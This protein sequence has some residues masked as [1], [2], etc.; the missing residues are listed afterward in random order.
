MLQQAVLG[1]LAASVHLG[2]GRVP[3]ALSAII[4]RLWG[5]RA[6]VESKADL[7]EAAQEAVSAAGAGAAAQVRR[8]RHS[9]GRRKCG[10]AA[11]EP[12]P[13]LAASVRS[14][15]H[16]V[17]KSAAETPGGGLGGLPHG[18]GG[19]LGRPAHFT[20][21][22]QR[23]SRCSSSVGCIP[24][25]SGAV[26][27]VQGFPRSSCQPPPAPPPTSLPPLTSAPPQEH[28]RTMPMSSTTR[29]R[30]QRRRRRS[31]HWASGRTRSTKA[32]KPCPGRCCP[33]QI[34]PPAAP[35]TTAAPRRTAAPTTA[36]GLCGSTAA[37][38]AAAGTQ[39]RVERRREQH[40]QCLPG[41]GPR[42]CGK[43]RS[44]APAAGG[45]AAERSGTPSKVGGQLWVSAASYSATLHTQRCCNL[46]PMRRA[47]CRCS[48]DASC[49]LLC[50][51]GEVRSTRTARTQVHGSTGLMLLTTQR[52][53]CAF[54][55]TG[56]E[57]NPHSKDPMS[58]SAREKM[59]SEEESR[60]AN[61]TGP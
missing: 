22:Q 51:G 57:V 48:L 8:Q 23:N 53:V 31:G 59:L 35:A 1:R 52:H 54:R 37:R 30:L 6:G 43:Q 20:T 4:Q 40:Q 15:H 10:A 41:S 42:C 47:D 21:P 5:S 44:L 56:E 58:E 14:S 19:C 49:R 3:A 24:S 29:R 25:S 28:R 50:A 2:R 61:E 38:R 36:R 26:A 9:A 27:A 18:R 33:Q 39:R 11:R 55:P 34:H 45:R 60:I 16:A 7:N 32:L 17:L 46:K 12:P 13:S